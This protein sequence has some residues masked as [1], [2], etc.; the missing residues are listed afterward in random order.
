MLKHYTFLLVF[1]CPFYCFAQSATDEAFD[2]ACDCFNSVNFSSLTL[3]KVS[4]S[5][6]SCIQEAFYTNLTGVLNE[7]NASLGDSDAM[8]KIAISLQVHLS[9]N[10]KGFYHFSVRMAEKDV[11]EVKEKYP[12]E[13]GLLYDFNTDNQFPVF[14]VITEDHRSMKFI[15]FRE[16]DGSTRFMDGIKNHKNTV[17]E[18]FWKDIEL[19]DALNKKYP[20][21]KEI[22]LIEEIRLIDKEEQKAWLEAFKLKNDK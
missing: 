9:E 13:R 11:V 16:F 2:K 10:C 22:L 12:S 14:T 6:D 7:N 17:V 18:I 19:Y 20:Y 5:A 8:H 3:A 21:Q 15:W 1:F 4:S